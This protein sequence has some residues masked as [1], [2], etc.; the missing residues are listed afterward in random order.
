M[1]YDDFSKYP[2]SFTEIRAKKDDDGNIA[3]PRDTLISI[4]RAIDA[5]EMNIE[6][7]YICYQEEKRED[8]TR[9]RGFFRGGKGGWE[10]DLSMLESARIDIWNWVRNTY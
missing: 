8:G 2:Q 5:K 7:V 10:R 3:T 6:S 9:T 1:N 4:L